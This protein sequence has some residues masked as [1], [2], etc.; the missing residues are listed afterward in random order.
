MGTNACGIKKS[1][2]YN[3]VNIVGAGFLANQ[4]YSNDESRID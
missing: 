3:G 2:L 1:A 4:H